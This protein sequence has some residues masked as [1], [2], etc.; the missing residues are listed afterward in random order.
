MHPRGQFLFGIFINDLVDGAVCTLSM[1]A[2]DPKFRG[3]AYLP[4]GHAAS[5]ATLRG[6]RHGPEASQSS[7]RDSA[8][9]CPGKKQSSAPVY[10]G[11]HTLENSLAEEALMG[12]KLKMRQQ[13]ALAARKE[14]GAP[15]SIRMSVASRSGRGS[16]PSPQQW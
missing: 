7:A 9:L 13:C 6:C 4:E 11:E 5:R 15:G 1:A 2:D 12:A 8:K 10:A 16:C 3:V 14:N